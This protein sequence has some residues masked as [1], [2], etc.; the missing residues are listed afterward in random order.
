MPRNRLNLQALR[1]SVRARLRAGAAGEPRDSESRDL[2]T[3]S[4]RQI[5]HTAGAAALAF[6]LWPRVSA[7]ERAL[8]APTPTG[9]FTIA[10]GTDWIAFS[11]DGQERWRI[12]ARRFG[13]SPRLY[14]SRQAEL[15]EVR[16][17]GATYP[18]TDLSADLIVTLARP[19]YERSAGV[20]DGAI[21]EVTVEQRIEGRPGD[22]GW[23]P[24]TDGVFP[25]EI[26]EL[27]SDATPVWTG[28]VVLP[29]PRSSR[30]FRLVIREYEQ[31]LFME[32]DRAT[33][34]KTVRRLVYAD[35]LEL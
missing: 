19:G 25:L 34:N 12:D 9:P 11:L 15:I 17:Q 6:G 28:P 5:F 30:P 4:H 26:P 13:G 14:F 27:R 33:E 3:V 24:V 23:A 35:I 32:T 1:D 22:L 29:E 7:A 31:H 2:R 21:V 10:S 16:L 8:P 20:R 18:G